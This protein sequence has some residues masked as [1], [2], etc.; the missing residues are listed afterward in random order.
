MKIFGLGLTRPD[1]NW[2]MAT[3]TLRLDDDSPTRRHNIIDITIT[4]MLPI[5][6]I[7]RTLY[8]YSLS[9]RIGV[10]AESVIEFTIHPDNPQQG[11]CYVEYQSATRRLVDEIR[12]IRL[13]NRMFYTAASQVPRYRAVMGRL[14]LARSIPQADYL[15]YGPSNTTIVWKLELDFKQSTRCRRLGVPAVKR[16]AYDSVNDTDTDADYT[17]NDIDIDVDVHVDDRKRGTKYYGSGQEEE[18]GAVLFKLF[19]LPAHQCFDVVSLAGCGKGRLNG[20]FA[21][22]HRRLQQDKSRNNPLFMQ[23]L[24]I[25]CEDL[26]SD[27]SFTQKLPAICHLFRGRKQY[28]ERP[29][30][31]NYPNAEHRLFIVC[32]TCKSA[33]ISLG[34]PFDL[35]PIGICGHCRRSC[36]LCTDC[37][38]LYGR[39]GR[40]KPLCFH[41]RFEINMN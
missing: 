35:G 20:I 26:S 4:A 41:C 30:G 32:A 18:I 37:S 24:I 3:S 36:Y 23:R 8:F 29:P 2:Q 25:Q 10:D 1:L 16:I 31:H 38:R 22:L 27:I 6:I 12:N 33:E 9:T 5:E 39:I 19:T 13:V 14:R 15:R 17:D 11:L 40:R 34:P 28:G 7:Q 21:A